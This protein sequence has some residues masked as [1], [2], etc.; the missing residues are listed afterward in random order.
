MSKGCLRLSAT[1]DMA[2]SVTCVSEREKIGVVTSSEYGISLLEEYEPAVQAIQCIAES[3]MTVAAQECT[4]G[5]DIYTSIYCPY[6]I[7]V[8]SFSYAFNLDFES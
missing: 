3:I 8:R 6:T 2:A 4:S 7:G 1:C 5:I